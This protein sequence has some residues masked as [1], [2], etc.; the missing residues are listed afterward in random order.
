LDELDPLYCDEAEDVEAI[1]EDKVSM[2]SLPFDEVI[3]AFDS[4]TQ[5]EVNM[6]SCFPF[7]DFDDDLF[8]DLESEEVLEEPLDALIPSCYDK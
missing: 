1:H 7:Q 3:Q 6:V 8:C 4:P 2:L 5:E